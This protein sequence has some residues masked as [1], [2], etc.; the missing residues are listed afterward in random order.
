MMPAP[1]DGFAATGPPRRGRKSSL[2]PGTFRG[3]PA[4]AK[5]LVKATPVWRWFFARERAVYAAF[6]ARPPGWRVPALLAADATTLVLERIAGAPVATRRSPHAELAA[7]TTAALVATFD[8]IAAYDADAVASAV[9][10]VA[11]RPAGVRGELRRRLLEDPDDPGWIGD[12]AR[13]CARRGLVTVAVADAL[14]DAAAVF[15]HGDALL[16]NAIAPDADAPA[17]VLVDWECAGRYP[18]GW[19]RALLWSQLGPVSRAELA[20]GMPAAFHAMC[21]F[22]LAREVRFLEAFGTAADHPMMVR[23]RADLAAVAA[24]VC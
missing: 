11:P 3:V 10:T 21:A 5:R 1:D 19:D 2:Q 13:T 14:D 4:V 16:R 20:A 7:A 22:A 8:A 23:H 9:A 12:G 18:P 24:R 15:G 6:A 17:V